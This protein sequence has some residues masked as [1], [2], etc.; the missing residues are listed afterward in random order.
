MRGKNN[1]KGRSYLSVEIS[2]SLRSVPQK[3]T[4][5]FYAQNRGSQQSGAEAPIHGHGAW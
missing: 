4:M 2:S 1:K 3:L 5:Y